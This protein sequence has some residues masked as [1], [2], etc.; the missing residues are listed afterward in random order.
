MKQFNLDEY[1]KNPDRKIVTRDGYAA[2]ILCTDKKGKWPIVALVYKGDEEDVVTYTRDGQKY[3]PKAEVSLND[4]FFAPKKKEYWINIYEDSYGS[5]CI[6]T[7]YETEEEAL[8]NKS[9]AL[10]YLK[11]IKVEREE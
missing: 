11:T 10:T 3:I 7:F 2:R 5:P 1:L 8:V 6:G 9:T 4:L